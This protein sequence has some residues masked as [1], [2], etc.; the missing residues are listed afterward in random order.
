MEEMMRLHSEWADEFLQE[1]E[2]LSDADFAIMK[3]NTA[4]VLSSK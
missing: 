1:V 4:N 2:G 3:T